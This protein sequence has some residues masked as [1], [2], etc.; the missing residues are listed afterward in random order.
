M[1]RKEWITDRAELLAQ[2]RH[3]LMFVQLEESQQRECFNE[4]EE[5]YNDMEINMAEARHDAIE[6]ESEEC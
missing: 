4:A 2:D 3:G 5:L 6:E 1:D